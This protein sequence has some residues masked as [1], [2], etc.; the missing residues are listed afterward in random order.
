MVLTSEGYPGN[1]ETGKP[2]VGLDMVR[3][4]H[5]FQSGTALEGEE[6]VTAGGRVLSVTA[7]GKDIEHAILNVYG[8]TGLIHFEGKTHRT[9][10]GRDLLRTTAGKGGSAAG[11][12]VEVK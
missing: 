8:S 7:F 11:L 2:V 4:A 1:V 12:K 3:A 6:L 9:D 10:I 5:V